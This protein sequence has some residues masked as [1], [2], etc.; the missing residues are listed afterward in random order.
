VQPNRS[1]ALRYA[2]AATLLSCARPG[3]RNG[4]CTAEAGVS[5][6]RVSGCIRAPPYTTFDRTP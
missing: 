3:V 1:N 6:P 5:G 4:G 2:S